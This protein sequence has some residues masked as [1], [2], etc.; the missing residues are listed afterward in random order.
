PQPPPPPPTRGAP[1]LGP[2]VIYFDPSMPMTTIQSRLD[3]L[4]SQQDSAQFGSGRYAYF[5]KPGQ[6]DLDVKVG[7]YTQVLGLGASPDD[8]T[9]RGAV[10]AK[11]D[12]LGGNNATCNFWR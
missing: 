9:I 3:A 2:N 7:F 8:V 5:F 10:R 11:A 4:Y 12:W 1:D 6:Y